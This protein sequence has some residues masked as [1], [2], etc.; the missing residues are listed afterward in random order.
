MNLKPFKIAFAGLKDGKHEFTYEIDNAFFEEFGFEE[1][2]GSAL[3]VVVT[4]DKRSTIMDLEFVSTGV[5]NLNCDLTNEPFDMPLEVQMDLVVK[6]GQEFNDENESLLILTHG[7][8]EFY[9]S[10]YIYEMLVLAVPAKRVH[11]GIEDGTLQS[12]I[13][14]KLDELK[15]KSNFLKEEYKQEVDPRW[16]ILKNLKTDNNL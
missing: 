1:F 14:K 15:P 3:N 9:V 12:D 2:N 8:Y 10:Q 16:D 6:F 11:P 13:V 4:M 7:E 5:V